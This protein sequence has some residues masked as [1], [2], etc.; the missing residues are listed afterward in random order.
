[1]S[2]YILCGIPASGKSTFAKELSECCNAKLYCYDDLPNAHNPRQKD[3][4]HAKMWTAIVDDLHNGFNVVCDDLHTKKQWRL[5]ILNA[6]SEVDCKKILV[7]MNTPLEICLYRNTNRQARLPDIVLYDLYDKYEP[8]DISEGWDEIKVVN[9]YESDF[10][11][12][13]IFISQ[14]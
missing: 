3:L 14:N 12:N 2:I 1:M 8:P 6:I 11:V 4:I 7:V 5:N 10:T 9:N 13:K